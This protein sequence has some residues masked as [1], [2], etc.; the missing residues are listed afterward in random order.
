MS[1]DK[2]LIIDLGSTENAK[3]ARMI[4]DLHVFSLVANYDITLEEVKALG[5]VKGIIYNAGPNKDV[6]GQEIV[7]RDEVKNLDIPSLSLDQA[8]ISKEDLKDFVFNKAQA[9]QDW[10]VENYYEFAIE[11]IKA[12]VQN[13][14]V[15][16]ALSGGVDSS[17]VAALL[18]K[19]IGKKLTCVHV[20]HGLLRK[21]ESEQV[22]SVFKPE[23]AE[24]FIYIDASE[25]FLAALEGV[26]DPER[27]RKIIGNLFI[28]VFSE[29]AKK[30]EA[31]D[32]LAQGTIYS[33][34]IES[35]S[36]TQATIKSHHNVGGLPEDLNFELVEPLRY[37]FKD[38]V[39]ALGEYLNLPHTMV[40]RQ[41]FPGPGLAIRCTG[42]ITK[43]RLAAV[44]ESDAIL[45]E[46]IAKANLDTK[47]WQYFT[48]VP[49]VKSTGIKKG[50]R[51]Y[52]W[53]CVIRAVNTVDAMTAE[54]YELPYELLHK[55]TYR[56]THEVKGINRV[57]YDFTPKPTGT[58]EWE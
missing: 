51:A 18:I 6:S 22:I 19:A 32:F 34:V 24:N 37:L 1:L 11:K 9:K 50:Q 21:G 44:R 4:R 46:E 26:S 56:I 15:L 27:K 3:L 43:E 41:P 23:L 30:L 14:K 36:K 25:K 48:I 38:E 12:K 40:Y 28:E 42:A 10:T 13:K 47:I 29:Q 16:L 45:R 52:E 55:L 33:D 31:I 17:V 54:I 49:D 2:I 35:G 8:K 53:P 39:R 58:I 5:D 57:L 7:V 20:N